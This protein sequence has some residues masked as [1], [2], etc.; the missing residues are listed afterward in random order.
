MFRQSASSRPIRAQTDQPHTSQHPSGS[1]PAGEILL[2]CSLWITSGC[3]TGT[4]EGGEEVKEEGGFLIISKS[5][6]VPSPLLLILLLF[7]W[8]QILTSVPAPHKQSELSAQLKRFP[9]SFQSCIPAASS[10]N[11]SAY[12]SCALIEKC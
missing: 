5:P 2:H 1:Q 10:I 3:C 8:T 6:P 9:F 11:S 4:L 7:A 12:H